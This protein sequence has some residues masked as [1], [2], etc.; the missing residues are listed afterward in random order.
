MGKRNSPLMYVCT[1]SGFDRTSVCW[2]KR[3]YS[4]N[5][6]RGIFED[7]T[8]FAWICGLDEGDDPFDEKNWIKPNPGLGVMVKLKELR[9]A[10]LKAKNDPSNLNTFLRFRMSVWTDS[11]ESW[12]LGSDW[13][14]CGDAIDEEALYGRQC[15]GAIDLSST[16]DST[17]AG[18]IFPPVPGDPKWTLLVDY[19]LPK[20]CI[21]DRVR[22]DKVPYDVWSKQGLFTLTPGRVVDYSFMRTRINERAVQFDMREICFDVWNSS[23][24]VRQ[25]EDDGFTMI[26]WAQSMQGM[27]AP[28]KRLKEIVLEKEARHGG[29]PVLRW[30]VNNAVIIEDSSGNKKLDKGRS[31]EKIDGLVAIVMALGRAMLV[32]DGVRPFTEPRI[33]YL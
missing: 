29:N 15:I 23:E 8:W 21:Q 18:Y 20:D 1:N 16:G 33:G 28:T 25:L 22:R 27:S 13:D 30:N 12:I 7:D 19:F 10:A 17:A 11:D 5:V 26:K 14:K 9:E 2:K 4:V 24:L 32:S 3:E 31:R 6:L